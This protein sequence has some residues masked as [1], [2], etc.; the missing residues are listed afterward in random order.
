MDTREEL[1]YTLA[2]ALA[3]SITILSSGKIEVKNQKLIP[4]AGTALALNLK[5]V[6]CSIN[7]LNTEVNLAVKVAGN[8]YLVLGYSSLKGVTHVLAI[9]GAPT[10]IVTKGFPSGHKQWNEL[11]ALLEGGIVLHLTKQD[12]S[13]KWEKYVKNMDRG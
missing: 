3:T 9:D 10:K 13:N 7:S 12:N 8:L 6:W 2:D 5:S 1:F 4:V 11:M